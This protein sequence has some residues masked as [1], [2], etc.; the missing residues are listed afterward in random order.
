[1]R[2]IGN[3]PLIYMEISDNLKHKKFSRQAYSFLKVRLRRL[4]REMYEGKYY[5]RDKN[6]PT[7]LANSSITAGTGVTI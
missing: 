3:T 7:V 4:R 1:M 2:L 6:L 5:T